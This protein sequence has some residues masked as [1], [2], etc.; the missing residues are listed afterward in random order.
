MSYNSYVRNKCEWE[1]KP[2]SLS[3]IASL[4][5]LPCL[6]LRGGT[7]WS[8]DGKLNRPL[9]LSFSPQG[10]VCMCGKLSLAASYPF[11]C[12]NITRPFSSC[13][14]F[15]Q[16]YW[17]VQQKSQW[18]RKREKR[19]EGWYDTGWGK[20]WGRNQW[21]RKNQ[22][23]ESKYLSQLLYHPFLLLF[24]SHRSRCAV[25]Q[26]LSKHSGGGSLI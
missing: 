16:L 1:T 2:I 13:L 3:F 18:G 20:S 10:P 25:Y 26:C 9:P 22:E 4:Y 7:S 15:C 17:S 11:I 23:K 5:F 8:P 21:K 14:F 12:Q 6:S 19:K 24:N